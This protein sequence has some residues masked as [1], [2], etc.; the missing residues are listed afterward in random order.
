MASCADRLHQIQ[1]DVGLTDEELRAAVREVSRPREVK[2]PTFHEKV[3]EQ[4]QAQKTFD[5]ERKKEKYRLVHWYLEEYLK[6]EYANEIY[7]EHPDFKDLVEYVYDLVLGLIQLNTFVIREIDDPREVLP[8]TPETDFDI[9]EIQWKEFDQ[10]CKEHPLKDVND[11]IRRREKFKLSR[12]KKRRRYYSKKRMRAYDPIFALTAVD[13]KEMIANLER[14]SKENEI[15]VREFRKMLD[16]LVEDKSVGSVALARFNE[17]T[18]AMLE[19]HKRRLK[20]FIKN[21]KSPNSTITL[22]IDDEPTIV[23]SS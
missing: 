2:L 5:K 21:C 16:S 12:E 14:I 22:D 13:E 23:F 7:Y 20:T 17:S 19:N 8:E 6:P 1:R 4:K 18:K 10:Y 9:P 15:R 3:K 11:I